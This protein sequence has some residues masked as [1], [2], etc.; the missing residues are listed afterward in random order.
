MTLTVYNLEFRT[1][2]VRMEIGAYIFTPVESRISCR[3]FFLGY[4]LR[5]GHA[6]VIPLNDIFKNP[7]KVSNETTHPCLRTLLT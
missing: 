6:D 5:L 3:F 1:K 2:S 4:L 7:N